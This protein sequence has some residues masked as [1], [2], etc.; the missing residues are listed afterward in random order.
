MTKMAL[1]EYWKEPSFVFRNRILS[2]KNGFVTNRPA[3]SESS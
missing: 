1:S 3:M 2:H